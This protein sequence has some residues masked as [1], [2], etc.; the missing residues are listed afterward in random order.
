[1]NAME[2]VGTVVS[3]RRAAAL[4]VHHGAALAACET[5]REIAFSGAVDP[6]DPDV[7]R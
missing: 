5:L 2:T 1:M 4:P 3:V 7:E 6:F